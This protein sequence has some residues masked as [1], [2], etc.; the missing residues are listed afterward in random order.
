MNNTKVEVI[1]LPL[2]LKKKVNKET[3]NSGLKDLLSIGV[4]S[5]S[6]IQAM[7]DASKKFNQ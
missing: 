1:I 3:I 5:E 2:S 6:D 4:W 7:E